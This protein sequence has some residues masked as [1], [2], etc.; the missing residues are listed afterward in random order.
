MKMENDDLIICRC[1][2]ISLGEI[3]EAIKDG[4]R[5]V[6]AVK[7]RTRAGMGLCQG[8]TCE[9]MIQGIIKDEIKAIGEK[10]GILT[11]RFPHRPVKFSVLG[12]TSDEQP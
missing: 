2:E 9:P 3:R 6:S 7:R 5:D 4:A 10:A 12:G 11:A 8:R 1:E